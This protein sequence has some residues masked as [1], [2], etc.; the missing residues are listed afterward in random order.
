MPQ[1]TKSSHSIQSAGI[2]ANKLSR[3]AIC[4]VFDQRLQGR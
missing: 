4:F 1:D 2:R 3:V